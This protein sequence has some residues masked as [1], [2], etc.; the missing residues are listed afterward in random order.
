M[1]LALITVKQVVELFILII[2]GV[3][4]QKTGVIKNDGK[5]LLSDI[6]IR[7][8]GDEV[9]FESYKKAKLDG[10]KRNGN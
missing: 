9:R 8:G 10:V 5:K 6:L 4:L 1:E 3:I 2:S 7:F